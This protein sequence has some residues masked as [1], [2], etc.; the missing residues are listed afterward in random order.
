[1]VLFFLYWLFAGVNAESIKMHLTQNKINTRGEQP[2]DGSGL[3]V[4]TRDS[5]AGDLWGSQ[6]GYLLSQPSV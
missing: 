6:L 2:L 1:M 4:D 5:E 3:S